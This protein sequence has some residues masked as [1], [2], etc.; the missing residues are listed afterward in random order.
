MT[1][2]FDQ[3]ERNDEISYFICV[4]NKKINNVVESFCK[5]LDVVII[6]T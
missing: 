3:D 5:N 6:G 1:S 2:C 4:I